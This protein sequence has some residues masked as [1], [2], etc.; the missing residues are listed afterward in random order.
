MCPGASAVNTPDY[1]ASIAYQCNTI[2]TGVSTFIIQR[3]PVKLSF[4]P[5]VP[6]AQQPC[7]SSI[8]HDS[9]EY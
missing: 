6:T 9:F 5:V 2:H 1:N 3:A 4:I 7:D 8:G